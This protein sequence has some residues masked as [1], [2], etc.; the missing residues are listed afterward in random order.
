MY[1]VKRYSIHKSDAETRLILYAVIGCVRTES[2]LCKPKGSSTFIQSVP[3][4][5]AY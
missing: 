1:N 5:L 3:A 2:S 4:F